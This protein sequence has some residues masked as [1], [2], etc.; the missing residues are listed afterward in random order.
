MREPEPPPAEQPPINL[1]Q[2][3]GRSDRYQLS[4]SNET[5]EDAAARRLRDASDARTR[6]VMALGLFFFAMA[7][8][9]TVFVGAVYVFVTGSADDKKW[10]AGL[11][12]AITS[13]LVGF[14]VGQARR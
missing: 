11:V 5:A 7:I 12:S 13:G 3:L 4:V 9:A 2:V 1:G 10:A 14:L 6:Q 8:A